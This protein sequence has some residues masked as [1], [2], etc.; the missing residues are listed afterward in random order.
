[1]GPPPIWR[2][3][4]S[5]G[6]QPKP[7]ALPA[8]LPQP[9]ACP[10]SAASLPPVTHW[11]RRPRH[12]QAQRVGKEHVW[13]AWPTYGSTSPCG[14]N[15]FLPQSPRLPP[16]LTRVISIW[17]KPTAVFKSW[18]KLQKTTTRKT[19]KRKRERS[20]VPST[21]PRADRG[22]SGMGNYS[23]RWE[24]KKG[25][26]QGAPARETRWP[27]GRGHLPGTRKAASIVVIL[28]SFKSENWR[29]RWRNRHRSL[30]PL[31]QSLAGEGG[32]SSGPGQATLRPLGSRYH[33]DNTS[34][35]LSIKFNAS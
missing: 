35:K 11:Q 18:W 33:D 9:T 10:R 21:S 17:A 13:P 1:M 4:E 26:G 24:T 19:G 22:K 8:G 7:P 12:P 30:P 29:Q 34:V 27:Q 31:R 5:A 28:A 6:V 2:T 16:E 23:K 32:H 14:N 25:S 20:E 3:P 15:L